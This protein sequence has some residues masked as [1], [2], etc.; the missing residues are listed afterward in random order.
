MIFTR[1]PL[2]GAWVIDPEPH[3]DERGSFSR[4]FDIEEFG[5]HGLQTRIVQANVS[6]STRAG[7]LRGLHYQIPPHEETKVVRCAR[8]AIYDV[9]VDLREGSATYLR[10]FAVELEPRAGRMLYAPEGFAHGFQTLADDTEVHYQ[11]SHEHTPSH[12]R[13]VRFD[14]PILSIDW[15]QVTRIVSQRDRELP[16]T[17]GRRGPA[18]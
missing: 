7:T 13:G 16:W 17:G 14:D 6:V 11:V 3:R 8:G 5:T 9:I 1:T 18:L 4:A 12:E 10:W 2:A 15:P